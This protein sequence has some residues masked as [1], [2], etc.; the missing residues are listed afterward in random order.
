VRAED[1]TG[2][3][4]TTVTVVKAIRVFRS[5]R[6]VRSDTSVRMVGCRQTQL[7]SFQ[8]C[9]VIVVVSCRKLHAVLTFLSARASIALV[10]LQIILFAQ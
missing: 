1:G 3:A 8:T 6:H 5:A 7:E 10:Y 9:T 4:L 2:D